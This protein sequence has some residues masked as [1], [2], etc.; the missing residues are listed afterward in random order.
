[1]DQFEFDPEKSRANKEKHGVDLGWAR[2]LWGETHIVI[3]ARNVTKEG[4]FLILARVSGKCF[5]A[6]FTKRG[7][8]IRIINCHRADRRLEAIYE[9]YLKG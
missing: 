2:R 7:E 4:R 6:V 3:P 9:S 5:A 8:A 1:M